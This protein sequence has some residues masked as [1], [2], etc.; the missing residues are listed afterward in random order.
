[1]IG[2]ERETRGLVNIYL[3]LQNLFQNSNYYPSFTNIFF[4]VSKVSNSAS[5]VFLCSTK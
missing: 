4:E 2:K 5:S 1:M 3:G